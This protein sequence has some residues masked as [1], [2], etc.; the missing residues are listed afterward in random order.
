MANIGP[1]DIFVYVDPSGVV[2]KTGSGNLADAGEWDIATTYA[3][4]SVVSVVNPG[5]LYVAVAENDGISPRSARASGVWSPLV[6]VSGTGSAGTATGEVSVIEGGSSPIPT[7]PPTDTS[8]I[9]FYV[10]EQ[11]TMFYW[12]PTKSAWVA[13]I[14]F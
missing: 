7:G 8:K 9:T 14:T 5:S 13:L 1:G 2:T 3:P 10:S 12:K 4:L 11:G 6:R